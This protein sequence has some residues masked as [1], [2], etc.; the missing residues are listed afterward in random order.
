MRHMA[1]GFVRQF[2]ECAFDERADGG[3][4]PQ[5]CFSPRHEPVFWGF[6]Q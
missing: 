3:N 1:T 4:P 5:N 6:Y 2:N